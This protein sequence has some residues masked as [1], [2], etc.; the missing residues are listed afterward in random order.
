MKKIFPLVIILSIL[1]SACGAMEPN[2]NTDATETAEAG[3]GTE[4]APTEESNSEAVSRLEV[5][6][7]ALRGVEVTVWTPWYGIEQSLF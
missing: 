7:E 3:Q 6:V 2:A 5:Q 1:L 4:S